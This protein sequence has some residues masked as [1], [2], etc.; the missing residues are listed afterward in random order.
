MGNDPFEGPTL[1]GIV[2]VDETMGGGKKR[3]RRIG[4]QGR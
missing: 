1:F 4:E 3:K 2:E